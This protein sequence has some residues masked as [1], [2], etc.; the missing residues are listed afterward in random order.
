MKYS[1][2]ILISNLSDR[3]CSAFSTSYG[4]KGFAVE[5][6]SENAL[7]LLAQPAANSK[8]LVRRSKGPADGH[9]ELHP[10]RSH[11]PNSVTRSSRRLRCEA[12]RGSY[13]S[14]AAAFET[15]TAV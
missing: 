5:S 2:L 11:R 8:W 6:N 12:G 1:G 9:G 13:F 3:I 15:D 4:L 14:L 7:P 10:P